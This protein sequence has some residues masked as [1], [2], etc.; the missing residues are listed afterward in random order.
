MIVVAVSRLGCSRV[1]TAINTPAGTSAIPHHLSRRTDGPDSSAMT[2][3]FWRAPVR[4]A[5]PEYGHELG[6][7]SRLINFSRAH[8][9]PKVAAQGTSADRAPMIME[10]GFGHR[11]P[12]GEREPHSG[13]LST[14]P[15]IRY[16]V[17]NP[18]YIRWAIIPWAACFRLWQ[19]SIQ[20]PGLFARKAMS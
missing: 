13:W 12:L 17:S 11:N 8:A 6:M 9:R 2:P 10:Y 15:A 1:A 18:S 16:G 5:F 19:W 14:G 20:I 4:K 7:A 3:P